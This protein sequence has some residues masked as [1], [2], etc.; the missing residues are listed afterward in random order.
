MLNKILQCSLGINTETEESNGSFYN[1]FLE[2]IVAVSNK[3][4]PRGVL[5]T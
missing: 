5:Y 1:Q 2:C 4:F 3:N